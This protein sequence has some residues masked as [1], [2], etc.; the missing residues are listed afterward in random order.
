MGQVFAKIQEKECQAEEG[1]EEGEETLHAVPTATDPEQA[2]SSIRKRRIL[3]HRIPEG[4]KK[5]ERTSTETVGRLSAE[6]SR[7]TKSL[8]AAP[9]SPFLFLWD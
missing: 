4:T 9:G 5:E 6:K 1:L 3:P 8:R 2:G 7:Q